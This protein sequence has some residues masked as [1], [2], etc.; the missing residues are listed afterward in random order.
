[1]VADEPTSWDLKLPKTLLG[2]RATLH[3]STKIS[4]FFVIYA[5]HPLL[6]VIMTKAKEVTEGVANNQKDQVTDNYWIESIIHVPT[7]EE[8]EEED[9]DYN[10]KQAAE[11][12]GA[13]R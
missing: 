1:M 5:R 6:P 4:P 3:H 12:R 11:Q 7:L 8:D 13:K 9:Q 10:P 2:Y